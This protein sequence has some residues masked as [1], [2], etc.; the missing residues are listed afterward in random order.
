MNISTYLGI[1][2]LKFVAFILSVDL[3]I[4]DEYVVIIL[5]L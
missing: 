4:V 3:G 1:Y 5:G 2:V